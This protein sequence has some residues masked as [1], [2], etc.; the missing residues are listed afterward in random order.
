MKSSWKEL[1]YLAEKD[2]LAFRKRPQQEINIF[3]LQQQTFWRIY[4]P[5]VRLFFNN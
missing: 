3:K 2:T 1:E 5:L 4:F